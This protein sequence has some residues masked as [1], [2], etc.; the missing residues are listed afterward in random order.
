MYISATGQTLDRDST[1]RRLVEQMIW[2]KMRGELDFV[3]L[4]VRNVRYIARFPTH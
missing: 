3:A 1:T 2:A 4:I